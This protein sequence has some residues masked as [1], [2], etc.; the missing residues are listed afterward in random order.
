M[1]E[2]VVVVRKKARRNVPS[3]LVQVRLWESGGFVFEILLRIC[4]ETHQVV[5][6]VFQAR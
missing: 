1:V 2:V 4:K 3:I 6:V 5:V